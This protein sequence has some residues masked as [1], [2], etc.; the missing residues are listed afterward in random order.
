[1]LEL[2]K[3]HNIALQLL[4][5][6][7]TLSSISVYNLFSQRDLLL[8]QM[9][10][11]SEALLKSVTASITRFQVIQTTM[12][13]QKLV[14]DVSLELEIFEFR[15]T[16]KDGTVINSMFSEEIGSK[17]TRKSFLAALSDPAQRDKFYFEERDFVPVMAI[18]HPVV[19]DG[20]TIGIIDLSVDVTEYA[21]IKD[22]QPSFAVARRQVDIR[23][24]LTAIAGSIRNSV[25]IYKTIEINQFLSALVD[26]TNNIRKISIIDQRGKVV[27]SSDNGTIGT[28]LRL[29]SDTASG[30]LITVDNELLYRLVTPSNMILSSGGTLMLAIDATPYSSNERLLVI[31]AAGTSALTIFMALL[32]AY[33]IY[34]V[35]LEQAKKE[36][37]RLEQMVKERTE[38]IEKLSNTDGL[39]GLWNRR[40][41]EEML[42]QEFQRASRHGHSLTVM[43]LDLD[44]FKHVNDTY[45]HLGGDEVLREAATR[46]RS[47]LR[48]TDFV[49]RYGGEE[50][51]VILIDTPLSCATVVGE[52]LREAI[53]NN[54]VNY[55]GKDILVTTSIGI[56]AIH[57]DDTCPQN[58]LERADI[59]LYRS[60]EGGR[61]RVTVVE[62]EASA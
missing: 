26:T 6:I 49:A 22:Q 17:F 29:P 32:I 40:H 60:K 47:A 55:E 51:V 52:K 11:D 14:N 27:M 19:V 38:E 36:N 15:Y 24:L 37:R 54:P 34:R 42:K 4:M 1:M 56:S 7:V 45:G 35:N 39:T 59:G 58:I 8:H 61:N 31:T 30:E 3:K 21:F 62:Y 50:I 41:L 43:L 5:L 33:S 2:I 9:H 13:L 12:S 20:E 25:A 48:H 44:H 16:D 53:A 46:V 28:T 10:L 23:N 57:A 18:T